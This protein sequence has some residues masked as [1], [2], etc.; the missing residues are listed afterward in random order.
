MW[1]LD[2]LKLP[3]SVALGRP[4]HWRAESSITNEVCA[5]CTCELRIYHARARNLSGGKWNAPPEFPY[6]DILDDFSDF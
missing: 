2:P 4:V 5:E 3:V 1:G 6:R